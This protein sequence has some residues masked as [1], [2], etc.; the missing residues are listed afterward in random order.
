MRTAAICPTCATYINALCVI[1]NGP[2]LTN[3]NVATLDNLETIVQK[4]NNNLVP[5]YG[6]GLPSNSAVYE[7]QIYIDNATGE[8]YIAIATGGGPADWVELALQS[9]IPPTPSLADVLLVGNTSVTPIVIQNLLVAPTQTNT[10][11]ADNLQL[12]DSTQDLNTQLQINNIYVEQIS[13]GDFLQIAIDNTQNQTIIFPDTSGQLALLSDT[14]LNLQEITDNGNLTDNIIVADSF[15]STPT[16][17][18]D[19][20]SLLGYVGNGTTAHGVLTLRED[21]DGTGF[22]STI[23]ADI[24]LTAD[25]TISIPD[26]DGT[27]VLSVNGNIPDNQG[28]V[29][30]TSLATLQT[31]TAGSNKDLIDGNNFQGTN[32]GNTQTGVQVIG[33]GTNAALGNTGNDIISIGYITGNNNTGQHNVFIGSSSGNANAGNNVISIG[34]G[35]ADTNLADDLIAIGVGAGDNN[36]GAASIFIGDSAGQI[37]NA[38]FAIGIGTNAGYNNGGQYSNFIGDNAGFNNT[39]NYTIGIGANAA[40]SNS[41]ANVIAIGQSVG[42][43]NTLSGMTIISNSSLPS[44]LNFAAAS[45]AINAGTGA[46]SGTYLYHDQT[47]NS[48]GAVRIP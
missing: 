34:F 39:G 30:V 40:D 23:T 35:T 3:T 44:Y 15:S 31:V 41:G 47:T 25:R 43:N 19:Y 12:F 32:A 21:S 20:A 33:I 2:N 10:I 26:A 45:A 5:I 18:S 9:A 38:G 24:D 16:Y 14:H 36:S 27:I 1:Y 7:G 29:I 46:T 42:I 28:D 6:S 48:I 4:I 11:S 8:I 22:A 13:T 17:L 37:N